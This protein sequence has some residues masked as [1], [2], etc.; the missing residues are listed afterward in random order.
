MFSATAANAAACYCRDEIF[1]AESTRGHV[2][3]LIFAEP[4][5]IECA[6]YI[7]SKG[8][9]TALAS[10][11]YSYGLH[12]DMCVCFGLCLA[13]AFRFASSTSIYTHHLQCGAENTTRISQIGTFIPN[14]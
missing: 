10:P 13:L 9:F 2:M 3:I 7:C 6:T 11:S 12:T 14:K 5:C 8:D 1:L 4:L